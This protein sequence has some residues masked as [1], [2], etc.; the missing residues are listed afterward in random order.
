MRKPIILLFVAVVTMQPASAQVSGR[1]LLQKLGYPA[2]S[3]LL[4]LHADD[5]GMSHSVDM[6]S[7]EAIEKGWVSSASIMV[8]CPWFNE[9]AEFARSHPAA[10]LGLHLTL[11]SEWNHYRWGPVNRIHYNTL[12]DGDGYFLKESVDVGRQASALDAEAEI[13]AQI[14][15][16]RFAGICFTHLDNHMGALAQNAELFGVYLRA[17][18]ENHV[19]LSVSEGEVKAYPDAFKSHTSL[20]V[21]SYVGPGG[22]KDLLEGFRKSFATL[23][24]GVYITIVHLGL[25]DAELRAIMQDRDEGAKSRQREFDLVRGEAFQKLLRDNGIRHIRWSDVA[26]VI[27]ASGAVSRP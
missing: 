3:K 2:E 8:P 24:P 27:P 14:E 10:D 11:T 9:V 7:F 23:K 13:D 22:E 25:D 16:A 15:K 12:S 19:A 4:I 20:P 17:G 6:A 26:K 18:E 5:V 1:D 21:L